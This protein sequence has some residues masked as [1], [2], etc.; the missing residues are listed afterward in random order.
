VAWT[1]RSENIAKR[2]GLHVSDVGY[3]GEALP[4][5]HIPET[6][7]EGDEEAEEEPKG[8]TGEEQE[9]G[10]QAEESDGDEEDDDDDEEDENEDAEKEGAEGAKADDLDE[11]ATMLNSC[12]LLWQGIVPR[13]LFHGFRFQVSLRLP[14]LCRLIPRP[15]LSPSA[16]VSDSGHGS[17][18][19]GSEGHRS[20]L[21]HGDARRPSHLRARLLVARI[22]T[23]LVLTDSSFLA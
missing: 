23:I 5:G 4:P 3:Y 15:S 21:G 8:G 9:E 17:Q 20:L 6:I 19:A 7:P 13:R 16:G 12:D 11:E 10:R 14:P 18:G 22:L 1:K 2:G